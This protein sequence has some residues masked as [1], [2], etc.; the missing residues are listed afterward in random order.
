MTDWS[1]RRGEW[2]IE[3]RWNISNSWGI[4]SEWRLP[5]SELQSGIVDILDERVKLGGVDERMR[6]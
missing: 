4:L 2:R 1:F 3:N 5:S 6:Q